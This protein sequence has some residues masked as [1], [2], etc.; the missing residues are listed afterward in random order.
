MEGV[1]LAFLSSV[2]KNNIYWNSKRNIQ[3]TSPITIKSALPAEQFSA[4][5]KTKG[6]IEHQNLTKV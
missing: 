3:N 2:K 5:D 6:T 4:S 1:L